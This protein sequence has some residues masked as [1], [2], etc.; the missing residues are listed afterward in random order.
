MTSVA[1]YT[2]T[3]PAAAVSASKDAVMSL[4]TRLTPT[5][6]PTA[7]RLPAAKADTPV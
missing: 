4:S 2:R 7:A 3:L 1:L 5:A 6:A